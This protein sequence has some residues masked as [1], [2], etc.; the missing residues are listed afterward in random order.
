MST[1]TIEGDHFELDGEPFRILAG[2]M[3]YFRVHP[4]YWKDR[5]LKL[6]AMGLNT[7]ETYVAWNLHEPH[8]GEFHFGDWL[9][10]ERYIELAGELG[11]Y[12]I[13]RPGPYICAEWEMGGL[14]AW[15]LKDP[16]M[17]LRCMYQP[18]LDAVGEYFSQLMHRLVPLQSTRGGPIIAMQVENE[19]GSY[20]NDTRYLKYLEELL[21]QCGVDVLLFTADGVADEMMQYGSLPHLFKAVNFGNRPGDAF[22][23]LREYQ[24]GG[25]LLVA[26]FWDGWF[27]HWGERHH[28]RSAGEVARVLDDL[29]SEGAS[30]NLYMFH[31]GTN[32]GFM[33]GANAFPSPHYTPTVTSYDYD[34]PLSECGNIT[35]KYEAMR[36]VIGKYVDLPEMPDF[37]PVVRHAYGKV[38]L[39]EWA[40]LLSQV[41]VLSTPEYSTVPLP[42]EMYDQNY[43][44]ILYETQLSGPRE[45]ARLIIRGLHDRGH[46]FVD[47]ELIGIVDREN[48]AK[49]LSFSVQDQGVRLHIL[50]EN[51]GRVNYGPDLADRKGITEGVLLG[52]QWLFGWTV[53][54]LP[55]EDLSA[56][57][58]LPGE[59]EEFPAFLRGTWTINGTPADTF[60]ALPGWTKGV[61][62][63]NGF[64][65]GRYW[66][67][68]PQKTLYVPAPLLKE[69]ENEIVVLELDDLHHPVVEFR[70]HAELG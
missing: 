25:P 27:D 1:L 17:K 37:P 23:K 56:I 33:N 14:P 66:K 51:M 48:H 24:T 2:A 3:H 46:V 63:I 58:Y 64:N 34:A 40:P 8:E 5:L 19:Y 10:I 41:D 60:L 47:N 67:R 28:T 4:A 29:L 15:L 49:P 18:Y 55:L 22:E 61:V 6:K 42:M 11:L 35:P 44:F 26:E 70:N 65:I 38:Q 12:V 50:V 53:Y 20:G 30:V 62:W 39:D 54:P 36:E 43:G 69:G 45:E 21:R 32:F 13:V 7:V 31:G 59:P 57:R 9:N 52:Q 16:Q 68:G